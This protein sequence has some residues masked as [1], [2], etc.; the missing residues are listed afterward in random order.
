MK[1]FNKASVVFLSSMYQIK[2]VVWELQNKI[3]TSS[4]SQA[5]VHMSNYTNQKEKVISAYKVIM[6]CQEAMR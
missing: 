6:V 2:R 3:R 4:S 1:N 5:H